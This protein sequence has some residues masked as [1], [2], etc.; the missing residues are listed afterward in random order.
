[1]PFNAVCDGTCLVDE[2]IYEKSKIRKPILSEDQLEKIESIIKEA[3]F[4]KDY[5]I[6]Y[7]YINGTILNKKIKIK[8]IDY[9]KKQIILSDNTN[10]YYKQIVNVKNI[11]LFFFLI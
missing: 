9:N 7:Y 8:S 1:M 4:N 6:I 10:I 2:I 11:W 3:Y 5:I